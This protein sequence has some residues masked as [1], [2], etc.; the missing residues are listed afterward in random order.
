MRTLPGG[1]R[2]A[3]RLLIAQALAFG[4][5]AALL[6][7]V[8]NALFLAEYGARW[9]PV[10]YLFIAVVGVVMS[11]AIARSARSGELI[12]I[13][14]IVLGAAAIVFF[15][16]WAVVA[17]TGGA[18]VSAPLLVL[19]PVV[20]QLGFVFIGAQA[21]RVL[22]IGGIKKNFPRIMAGFPVGAVV[23]GVLGAQI[24][25][26]FDRTE[27]LLLATA[28]AQVL[29]VG[30]VWTAGRRYPTELGPARPEP[31]SHDVAPRPPLR[32]LLGSRFVLLIIAYQILSAVA[33]Q[34]A[35]FLVFDRAAARYEDAASLAE[36][37]ARYTAVMNVVSIVFLAA[38]AGTL[39]RRFGLKLGIAANPAV[40]AVFAGGMVVTTAVA[41]AGSL[42][43][44]A[45]VAGAR[46][47]D[48][49]LTDGTTRTS[50]NATYQVLPGTERLAVQTSVEGVGVPV[51]IGVA[52]VIIIALGV[53]P[54]AVGALVVATTIVC[55]VWTWIGVLLYREYGGAL[56]GALRRSPLL[57][58]VAVDGTTAEE[59]AATRLLESDDE[60]EVRL[61]LEL[62]SEMSSL[63]LDVELRRLVD[64]ERPELRLMALARLAESGDD[65]ARS[66]LRSDGS[67]GSASEDAAVRARAA[68]ALGVLDA[69]DRAGAAHLLSD[70][71]AGVRRAA[72]DAVR[73]GDAHA[74]DAVLEALGASSTRAAAAT[75]VERLGDAA[76]PAVA[77][78]LAAAAPP[79]LLA[80]R[81]V[82]AV[83]LAGP[84]PVRDVLCAHVGHPDRELG[85][86][87]LESLG[88]PGPAPEPLAVDLD[89]VLLEDARHAARITGA[90]AACTSG[91]ADPS[92][93]ARALADELLLVRR[94]VAAG[95]LARHGRDRLGPVLLGLGDAEHRRGLALEALEVTF[96]RAEAALAMPVL[97]AGL[98]PAERLAVLPVPP[99]GVPAD[100]AGWLT[101]IVSDGGDHWRSPWLQACAL[102]ASLTSGFVSEVDI[103]SLRMLGDPIV[104][105]LL[106]ASR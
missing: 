41:G 82:R 84:G 105:E 101:D 17:S 49:A 15:A 95:R 76:A 53:L 42:S 51:A 48:I 25:T 22:D 14:T 34:L 66:R 70:P 86:A 104:D 54:F 88:M 89:A 10:T 19:F 106:A 47:A 90:I 78:V 9:L 92:V 45:V 80:V 69:A 55:A 75:A 79:A 24:V 103:E 83:G 62:L 40:L 23:G 12:K 71:D 2:A 93:L 38:L 33:S 100:V 61:G 96:D 87:L 18:W 44:L 94:R 99:G 91:S 65:D 59:A 27:I 67:S 81:V 31:Q 60:R 64:D 43:L 26:W 46:I 35:D 20:L 57:G 4:V 29:F 30:L 73:A 1:T 7:I 50:I 98:T 36:F 63:T 39:L 102:H 32:A 52:G 58:D 3:V 85:L 68:Q 6:G 5:M 21:G 77:R 16:A 11:G 28:A 8:A 74:V 97:D 56:V 72:L 13:A 37:V